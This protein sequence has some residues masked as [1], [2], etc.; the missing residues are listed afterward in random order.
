MLAC[1]LVD[2]GA[3]I[4]YRSQMD[5]PDMRLEGLF[6]SELGAAGWIVGTSDSGIVDFE[7]CAE[8]PRCLELPFTPRPIASEEILFLIYC[9]LVQDMPVEVVLAAIGLVATVAWAGERTCSSVDLHVL[10]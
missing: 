6:L 5:C 4:C 2:P 3:W 10:V 8:P 9:M 1:F 7:V